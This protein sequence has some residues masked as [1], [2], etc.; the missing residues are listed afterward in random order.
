MPY[1]FNVFTGNLD[2]Y[3]SGTAAGNVTGLPP[4]T[5]K[6]IARWFGTGADTIQD[7]KTLVQDSGAIQA[8]AF[9]EDRQINGN[10]DVPTN[11]TWIADAIEMQPGASITMHPGSKIVIV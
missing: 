5:D 11:Y 4:S 10:V 1:K 3:Q 7:S 8:Q 6:A 9:I 2:Y